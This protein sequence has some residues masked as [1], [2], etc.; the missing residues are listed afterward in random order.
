MRARRTGHAAFLPK[1]DDVSV[2]I[3][4]D[5]ADAPVGM[6]CHVRRPD[7]PHESAPVRVRPGLAWCSAGSADLP[8]IA[9]KAWSPCC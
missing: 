6:L 1:L 4:S 8:D 3:L 2:G 5:V 9:H 7:P